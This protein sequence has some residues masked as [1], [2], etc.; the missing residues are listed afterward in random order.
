MGKLELFYSVWHCSR[1]FVEIDPPKGVRIYF[2]KGDQ[3]LYGSKYVPDVPCLGD[4]STIG[5][6]LPELDSTIVIYGLYCERSLKLVLSMFSRVVLC[7]PHTIAN[8]ICVWATLRVLPFVILIN[9]S[10]PL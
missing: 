2:C 6:V 5:G 7:D 8:A 1:D 10:L 9:K 3:S 4:S